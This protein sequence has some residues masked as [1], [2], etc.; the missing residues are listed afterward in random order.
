MKQILLLFFGL[1]LI[2]GTYAQDIDT[3]M[4]TAQDTIKVISE[5]DMQAAEKLY[6]DGVSLYAEKKYTESMT[7]FDEAIKI[8]ANFP[9]AYYNRALCNV[10]LKKPTAA[11]ADL[12]NVILLEPSGK[13]FY[14]RGTVYI[15]MNDLEAAK[16]D[17]Q[18]AISLDS[19]DYKAKSYYYLGGIAFEQKKYDQ[20]IVHY[21]SALS[22]LPDNAYALNDRG[23]S[24]RMLEKLDAAIED[25]SKAIKAKPDMAIAY[26]NR[27][28][29][30][31]KKNDLEGAV[32]DYSK[33]I[34]IKPEFVLAINA[35]G[36]V[37]KEMDEYEKAIIDFNKVISLDNKYASAFNNRG[38]VRF[39][40][41][42]YEE[43]VKDYD[44][45]IALD[46][47]YG[48]AYL[49]RGI[50]KEMLRDNEGACKDWLKAYKLGVES[51]KIYSNRC[52]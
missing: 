43:A 40:M 22:I 21:D 36:V 51:A 6:N 45:A 27:A 23:S 2:S 9:K 52:K 41:K 34:E 8:K 7:K 31:R 49:N 50:A 3:T 32:D 30:K 26:S 33:A 44:K 42:N 4:N 18:K 15:D 12:G 47:A 11:L 16:V 38:N 20:A 13:V 48:F 46:D 37:Y 35:R 19:A 28:S 1:I 29:V 24:N 14:R 5:E 10:E 17:F 25:Y 39:K